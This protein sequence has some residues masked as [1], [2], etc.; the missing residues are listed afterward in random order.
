MPPESAGGVGQATP[1]A[2]APETCSI[3]HPL[4]PGQPGLCHQ[5]GGSE[6]T[7]SPPPS[8]P[9]T[10]GGAQNF[11]PHPPPRFLPRGPCCRGTLAPTN[12]QGLQ[13]AG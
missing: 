2:G 7:F 8:P 6:Y 10:Q 12:Q 13:K 9:G 5:H 11:L 1:K 4:E 3:V